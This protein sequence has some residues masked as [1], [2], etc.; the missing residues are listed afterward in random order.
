M[1]LNLYC[2]L[3]VLMKVLLG[4][5]LAPVRVPG[6]ALNSTPLLTLSIA[7]PVLSLIATEK[8][9]VDFVVLGIVRVFKLK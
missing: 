4:V 6:S 5:I 7:Y 8:L 9:P 3:L 2:T 1:K